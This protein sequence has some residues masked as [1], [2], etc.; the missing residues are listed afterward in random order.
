[1]LDHILQL[2]TLPLRSRTFRQ[3]AERRFGNS[4]RGLPGRMWR[5][6]SLGQENSPRAPGCP[7]PAPEG[8]KVDRNDPA[9]VEEIL[10]QVPRTRSRWRDPFVG[11]EPTFTTRQ[12]FRCRRDAL[13]PSWITRGALAWIAFRHLTELVQ[14][15][16]PRRGLEQA[17][18]SRTAPVKS[19]SGGRTSRIRA[20][21]PGSRRN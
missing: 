2:A 3:R 11:D 16:G 19:P 6:P 13:T 15:E 12:A 9:A 7:R 1:M 5:D 20:M 8:G 10:P 4:G 21:S 14:E 18:L 17:G